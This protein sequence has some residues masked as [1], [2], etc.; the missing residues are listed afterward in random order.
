MP[1][2]QGRLLAETPNSSFKNT[3]IMPAHL[4][5]AIKDSNG[6]HL[7]RICNV[8]FYVVSFLNVT[9]CTEQ[10]EQLVSPTDNPQLPGC[11]IFRIITF[12][13]EQG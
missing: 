3:L 9:L 6:A 8:C 13:T 4:S 1:P 2:L 7:S 10:L 11:G 12:I 5:Y